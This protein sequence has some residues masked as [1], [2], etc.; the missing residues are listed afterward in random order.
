MMVR[1]H[2]MNRI[3]FPRSPSIT[4]RRGPGGEPR[5]I[6]DFQLE[7][8]DTR[9]P[10]VQDRAV[11]DATRNVSSHSART[12]P[13]FGH[14]QSLFLTTKAHA[15]SE[16]IGGLIRNKRI[17][18]S[19][20]I[21]LL[22]NG[23]G[24]YEE[25]V[26]RFFKD[27]ETRPQFILATNTHGAYTEAV[28]DVVHAASGEICYGVVE[29]PLG[30]DQALDSVP[31]ALERA[32]RTHNSLSSASSDASLPLGAITSRSPNPSMPPSPTP[33]FAYSLH[34]TVKL[35][36]EL[37]DSLNVTREPLSR[38]YHRLVL[39]LVTN[40]CVNPLTALQNINNGA[41][42]Q[43]EENLQQI[44]KICQEV[45]DV[46][47]REAELEQEESNREYEASSDSRHNNDDDST[48]A[49]TRDAVHPTPSLNPMP[50]HLRF[51]ITPTAI[52]MEREVLRVIRLTAPNISSM[53]Q[54]FRQG[55][56]TEIEYVN[57]YIVRRGHS[58]GVPVPAN[59]HLVEMVREKRRWRKTQTSK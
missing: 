19:T 43:D 47:Q 14:I 13:P 26:D 50:Y 2:Q 41:L 48:S 40:C 15:A 6:G 31:T 49:T 11:I 51:P 55:K 9:T 33:P 4:L 24:V 12:H 34:R 28:F 36:S 18:S 52:E 32:L 58:L 44:T 16:A 30:R 39:K 38:L 35:L 25:L 7:A 29:D 3:R 20:T 8:V 1:P 59:E 57:A 37:S 56:E 17:S 5:I 10:T 42:L 21:V 22:L 23:M 53:L 54:D 46:F 27:P 45:A